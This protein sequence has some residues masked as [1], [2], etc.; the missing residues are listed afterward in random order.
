VSGLRHDIRYALRALRRTPVFAGVAIVTLAL[1]IGANTAIFTLID[2]LMLRALPV[3]EPGQLVE[4]LSRYPGEPDNNGFSLSVYELFRDQNHVFSD[5]VGYSPAR[6]QVSG[7]RVDAETLD[8]AYVT[9]SLF[10]ALGVRPAAGRLLGVDDDRAG[11]ATAAVISWAYWRR[12]FNLDPGIV[13]R[14]LR[15][16][17][18]TVTIVGVMPRELVALDVGTKP[19]VWMP[20]SARPVPPGRNLRDQFGV[21]L[22]ARLKPDASIAQARADMAVLNRARVEELARIST[23]PVWRQATLGV[24]PAAAGFSTLSRHY[25]KP[26]VALMM[27]VALLLLVACTNLASLLLARSAARQREM[28]IRVAVGAGRLRLVRQTLVESLLLSA[29]GA[30]PGVALAYLGAGALARIVTSGP[31]IGV[32]GRI[33]IDIQ[34]DGRL[35]L[36]TLVMTT[37][38]GVIFGLA[39]AWHAFA[40]TP[41][42]AIR[43]TIG[44]TRSHRA[45]ASSSSSPRWRCRWC[46]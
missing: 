11:A 41:A 29:A 2:T 42:S 32:P 9:G 45:F 36:F 44:E 37:A 17:R 27:L 14:S 20:I 4:L 15:L 6:F 34:P 18:T 19:D 26:L 35:L 10:P 43:T 22:L 25:G 5:L 7:E 31:I 16:D 12:S 38:T 30:I 40:F 24:E 13:G 3:R 46:C 28:A 21:G 23:N 1:G 8:G 33:T 39:P